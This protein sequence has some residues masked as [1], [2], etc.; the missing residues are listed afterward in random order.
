V[1]GQLDARANAALATLR[2]ALAVETGGPVDLLPIWQSPA[3][4]PWGDQSPGSN[5]DY[6]P[7]GW[8]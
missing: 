4:A 1:Y 3:P 8:M 7:W 2:T 6:L 5:A